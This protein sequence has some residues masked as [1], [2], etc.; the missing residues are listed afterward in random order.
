MKKPPAAAGGEVNDSLR[1][2]PSCPAG[3]QR[4]SRG[5]RRVRLA[6]R[7]SGRR[8]KSWRNRQADNHTKR[9]NN[10]GKGKKGNCWRQRP[11]GN[12]QLVIMNGKAEGHFCGPF[13]AWENPPEPFAGVIKCIESME[14][15][16]HS[17]GCGNTL[18]MIVDD[19]GVNLEDF[20]G[21]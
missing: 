5:S 7:R 18:M 19:T 12:R 17:V 13:S 11:A 6:L 8:K 9:R 3:S 14:V 10:H 20:V 1:G 15:V 21:L 16:A 4:S 2:Y